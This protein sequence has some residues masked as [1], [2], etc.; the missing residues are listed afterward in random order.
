[1]DYYPDNIV[2]AKTVADFQQDYDL[3]DTNRKF[4]PSLWMKIF[5]DHHV[6]AYCG[7]TRMFYHEYADKDTSLKIVFLSPLALPFCRHCGKV[8]RNAETF[9]QHLGDKK[10]HP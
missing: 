2:Y 4:G 7:Y 5:E 10:E 1:M 6:F 8:F 9:Q 3:P